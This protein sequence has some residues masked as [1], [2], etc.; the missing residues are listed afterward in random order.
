MLS[1]RSSHPDN[2]WESQSP[3]KTAKVKNNSNQTSHIVINILK[4]ILFFNDSQII[5]TIFAS[6]GMKTM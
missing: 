1:G 4:L 5:K 2:Y 6:R 3:N